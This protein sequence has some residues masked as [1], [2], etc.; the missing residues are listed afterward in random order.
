M[1]AKSPK[2][3]PFERARGKNVSENWQRK[4]QRMNEIVKVSV[5][6]QIYS[7]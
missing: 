6:V 5:T 7:L 2:N 1:L 3:H 4:A